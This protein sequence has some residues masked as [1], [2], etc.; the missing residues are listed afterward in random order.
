MF[1]VINIYNSFIQTSEH[2][3]DLDLFKFHMAIHSGSLVIA[4]K[5]KD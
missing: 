3:Y 2:V 1:V 4:I 5:S